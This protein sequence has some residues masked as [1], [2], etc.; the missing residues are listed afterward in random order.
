[1]PADWQKVN[2]NLNSMESTQK[3]LNKSLLTRG[4]VDAKDSQSIA[5]GAARMKF[6]P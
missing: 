3:K 4:R 1:M 5:T 6:C 2:S